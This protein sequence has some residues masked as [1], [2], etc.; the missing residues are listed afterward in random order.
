MQLPAH[1]LLQLYRLPKYRRMLSL[2]FLAYHVLG[3]LMQVDTHDSNEDARTALQLN[4]KCCC[5]CFISCIFTC[6]ILL[7]TQPP[8]TSHS[9]CRY[10]ELVASGPDALDQVLEGL[11][12]TGRLTAFKVPPDKDLVVKPF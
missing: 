1:L 9:S 7:R 4:K 10:Q 11:Y 6:F 8:C 12:E 3:H 2:R 5:C